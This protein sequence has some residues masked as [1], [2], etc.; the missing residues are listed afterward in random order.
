MRKVL[1]NMILLLGSTLAAF[2]ILCDF[3]L[4]FEKSSDI[5]FDEVPAY[6]WYEFYIFKIVNLVEPPANTPD[7]P[8]FDYIAINTSAFE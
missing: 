3:I 2:K 5:F 8:V 6:Y 1:S 7:T 4:N